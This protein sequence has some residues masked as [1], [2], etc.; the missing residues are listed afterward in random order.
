MEFVPLLNFA[1][2]TMDRQLRQL[3]GVFAFIMMKMEV[4]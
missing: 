2:Q 3:V 1:Q 4:K